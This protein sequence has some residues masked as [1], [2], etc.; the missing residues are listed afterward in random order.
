MLVPSVEYWF[1]VAHG[2]R[3]GAPAPHPLKISSTAATA[4]SNSSSLL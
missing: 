1:R 2:R 4:V 3:A